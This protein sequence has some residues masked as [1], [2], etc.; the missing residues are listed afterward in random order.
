HLEVNKVI[1]EFGARVIYHTDGAV[2]KAV[3]G[4]ID[5]GIDVLQALQFDA[6]GM[7]PVELKANYGA[8][9]CFEGG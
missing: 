2:M 7:D 9:L 3:P 1:H 6:T 5:M 4:L 8:Q